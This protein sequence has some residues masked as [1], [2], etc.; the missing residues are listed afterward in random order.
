[1]A[2][3]IMYSP[4]FEQTLAAIHRLSSFERVGVC[5]KLEPKSKDDET[6][7]GHDV[8]SELLPDYFGGAC[9]KWA[10][11]ISTKLRANASQWGLS[12]FID[13]ATLL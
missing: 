6:D 4:Y 3:S 9:W 10:R 11:P 8:R 13:L 1:M 5:G 12:L 7:L 2:F